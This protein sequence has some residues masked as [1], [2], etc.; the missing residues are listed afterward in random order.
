MSTKLIQ[1][2]VSLQKQKECIEE[3]IQQGYAQLSPR[4]EEMREKY[5]KVLNELQKEYNT[6]YGFCGYCLSGDREIDNIQEFN[7]YFIANIII[8][9]HDGDCDSECIKIPYDCNYD[10]TF[11][12][13]LKKVKRQEHLEKMENEKNSQYEKYLELKKKYEE[14]K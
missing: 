5:R 9:Y 12:Q 6:Q 3:K 8:H 2:V 14:Q 7:N 11:A 4:I 10:D 1:E 13:E